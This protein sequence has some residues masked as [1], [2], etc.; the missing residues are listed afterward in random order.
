VSL[1]VS[2]LKSATTPRRDAR[3][4]SPVAALLFAASLLMLAVVM[5]WRVTNF[6]SS[7]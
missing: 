3:S 7:V 6:V 5:I 1:R 2:Q 4:E